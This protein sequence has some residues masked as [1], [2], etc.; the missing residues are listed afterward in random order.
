MKEQETGLPNAGSNLPLDIGELYMST[1]LLITTV[2]TSHIRTVDTCMSA[3]IQRPVEAVNKAVGNEDEWKTDEAQEFL[4][5]LCTP[6][7]CVK[8]SEWRRV[9]KRVK[10]GKGFSNSRG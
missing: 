4:M 5:M 3:A 8:M 10:W 6:V 7:P 2:L 1:M 9:N